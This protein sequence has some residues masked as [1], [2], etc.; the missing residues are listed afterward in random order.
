MSERPPSKRAETARRLFTK[1]AR[2][3]DETG[4]S[5]ALSTHPNFSVCRGVWRHPLAPVCIRWPDLYLFVTEVTELI[6]VQPVGHRLVQLVSFEPFMWGNVG[7]SCRF[8]ASIQA[9]GH[10]AGC[11]Y[12]RRLATPE[13]T[14]HMPE[15][16]APARRWP[17][18]PDGP[19]DGRRECL[20]AYDCSAS[21]SCPWYDRP[22]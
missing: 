8:C 21:R 12:A 15:G 5:R 11:R 3:T 13:T 9:V 22:C 17:L 20:C 18:P 14:P 16:A 7:W 4:E 19:G 1:Y 10:V 6:G 2:W